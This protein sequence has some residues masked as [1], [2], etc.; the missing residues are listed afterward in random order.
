MQNR[1][2]IS[3]VDEMR[4]NSKKIFK[5]STTELENIIEKY[6][7]KIQKYVDKLTE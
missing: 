5:L 1:Y 3:A 6:T 7:N 2:G 4:A